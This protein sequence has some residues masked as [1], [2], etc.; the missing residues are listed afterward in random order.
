MISPA[1]GTFRITLR[2]KAAVKDPARGGTRLGWCRVMGLPG[3]TL[4]LVCD[5]VVANLR[6]VASFETRLAENERR[7][8]SGLPPRIRRR[9]RRP[10]DDLVASTRRKPR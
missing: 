10:L 6:L 8:R 3:I 7:A 9:R 1:P 4:V 2:P 5:V